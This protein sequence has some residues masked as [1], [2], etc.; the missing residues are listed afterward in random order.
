MR[1]PSFIP[2]ATKISRE[3]ME[4][5]TFNDRI[6]KLDIPMKVFAVI[7]AV[8]VASALLMSSVSRSS[9]VTIGELILGILFFGMIVMLFVAE[10][11]S[12]TMAVMV[13]G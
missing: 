5:A 13:D 7:V 1:L 12:N 6:L 10:F 9:V 8:I 4:N 2:R 3:D 11:I